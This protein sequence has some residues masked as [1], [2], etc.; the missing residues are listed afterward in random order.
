[1]AATGSASYSYESFA[2][3]RYWAGVSDAIADVV[4]SL[5]DKRDLVYEEICVSLVEEEDS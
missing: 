5:F 2:P 3:F 1:M 4:A